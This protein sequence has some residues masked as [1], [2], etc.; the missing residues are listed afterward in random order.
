MKISQ[1]L[2]AALLASGTPLAIAQDS[3]VDATQSST[4]PAMEE[5]VVTGQRSQ[6][7]LLEEYSGGQVARGGR[8]GLLGNLDFLDVPFSGTAYTASLAAA[9]QAESIGDVLQNDPVVRV[10]KGF[11]NFQE[12][13]IL[14]GF[15]VYSDDITLNGVYG[16]LPRQFVA[17]ELVERVEV[18]RGANAFLNGAAPGGSGVGGTV[19]LVPKRAPSGG[20]KRLTAGYESDSQYQT[21]LD[22]GHR[23]GQDEAWG[24]RVNAVRR[25]GEAAIDNQ[26]RELNV[27]SLGT[28][29]AGERFRFTADFGHQDN[30]VDQPLPQVTPLGD[31]PQAPEASR[32]F[33]QPWTYSDEKQ[34]FGVIRGEYDV[35]DAV[36][37]WLAGGARSGEEAN[38]LA[39]PK[40]DAEGNLSSS[41]FDN[42]REDDVVSLDGGVEL[43]FTTGT[44]DHTL[45]FSASSV[46]LESKNAFAFYLTPFTSDLY[47]PLVATPPQTGIFPGGDL[48]D[49]LLTEKTQNKSLALAYTATLLDDRLLATVGLR[50]QSITTNTFDYNDGSELSGYDASKVTPAL[51]LVWKASENLSFYGNYAE[52]LQPGSVVPATSGGVIISNAGEVIDPLTGEQVELGVKYDAGAFGATVSAFTLERANTILVDQRITTSG[53]QENKGIEASL[54][55]EPTEGVRVIGGATYLKS[56]L[57]RTQDG[58]NQGNSPIGVPELQAN[59]NVEWDV[60]AA[61][62]LTLE[63]RLVYTDSQ[64]ANADNTVELDSWQ[65][66]DLGARYTTM[67]NNKPITLRARLDNVFDEQYWASTGGFPGA[68]YLILGN[69]RTLSVSASIDF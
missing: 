5:M 40:S 17:V 6:V 59:V 4:E 60:L 55:G 16:I 41:R 51:G 34:T 25:D 22:V 63:A 19:N 26:E 69:P 13:Y 27:L 37:V 11:G 52:S 31:I 15:P 14:R 53:Q 57:A 32:N 8:A 44:T 2:L 56:E 38:L 50:H 30:H 28:D 49:P 1:K 9:Q 23:F 42:T 12:V 33:A 67:F 18:F 43:T 46:A 7:E 64:Y 47:D 39:N 48:N 54:F 10:A 45:V 24:I 3:N 29:Y 66:F 68:N 20:V 62:G 61:A 21:A 36:K 65:R 35:N 58:L